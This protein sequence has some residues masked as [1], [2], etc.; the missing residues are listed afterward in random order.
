MCGLFTERLEYRKLCM[1]KAD[2]QT[3]HTREQNYRQFTQ[4]SR[5]IDKSHNRAKILIS[6]TREQKYRQV[7]Q[8]SRNIDKSHK[9]AKI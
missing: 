1:C 9:R 4:E 5:N 3:S 7:T 8:E 2:I 6:H